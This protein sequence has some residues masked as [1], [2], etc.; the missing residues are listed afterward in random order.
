MS[1]KVI[2]DI[3]KK[4]KFLRNR[5]EYKQSDLADITGTTKG[6]ISKIENGRT[7][8][9]LPVLITILQALKVDFKEFFADIPIEQGS[10]FY[11]IRADEMQ[12]I[13]KEDAS[14]FEYSFIFTKPLSTSIFEVSLL[15]I[16]PHSR[17]DP[18]S[19]DAFEFKYVISGEV[20]YEI[21]EE[22]VNLKT[23]DSLF[24]DGRI[25]HVPR[26]I[27]LEPVTMLVVYLF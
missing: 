8:P 22:K 21:G 16:Q 12:K 3:G 20:Q 19:T 25:L 17:R 27:T 14:G 18:I 7:V 2:H 13:Y 15:T 23:G 24:F 10:N 1:T 5:N 6:L 26:N 9:S 4:I 11:V